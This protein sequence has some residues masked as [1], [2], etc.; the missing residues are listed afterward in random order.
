MANKKGKSPTKM[1]GFS[2]FTKSV[3]LSSS[4]HNATQQDF[5]QLLGLV[6]GTEL[7]YNLGCAPHLALVES[8]EL[9]VEFL[10]II[11]L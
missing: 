3:V 8:L 6:L 9:L 1:W 4:A 10:T 5:R 7:T 11:G 2:Y